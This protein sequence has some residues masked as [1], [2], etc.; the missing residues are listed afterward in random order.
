MSFNHRRTPEGSTRL[1]A[2]WSSLIDGTHSNESYADGFCEFHQWS[3]KVTLRDCAAVGKKKNLLRVTSFN[4]ISM[5]ANVTR[6]L[7]GKKNERRNYK[8]IDV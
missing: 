6:T 4:F 7:R 8:T 3:K 1:A 5:R 2:T